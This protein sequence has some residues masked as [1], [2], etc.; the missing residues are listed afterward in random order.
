MTKHQPSKED[1]L[2]AFSVEPDLDQ[3][4]LERYLRDYPDYAEE[5][6]DL[7]AEL[8]CVDI[9]APVDLLPEEYVLI[10]NGW[11]RFMNAN[12]GITTNPF[13]NLSAIKLKEI[14][15]TLNI[16]RSV[17]SAFRECSVIATSVPRQFMQS[18]ADA[19]GCETDILLQYLM[20]PPSINLGRSYKSDTKPQLIKAVSFEQLLIDA[21]LPE[22]DRKRLLADD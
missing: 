12:T 8:T 1:V 2:D 22:A 6:V 16:K 14:A 4:T 5:I 11:K 10:E 18:L 7:A 3:F 20:N 13:A 21:E 15:H 19:I 17:L 9:S